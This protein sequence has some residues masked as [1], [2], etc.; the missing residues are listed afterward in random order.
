MRVG[1]DAFALDDHAGAGGVPRGLFAPG[2]VEVGQARSR[3]D[4]HHGIFEH[5]RDS[6]FVLCE[7]AR[8]ET[9]EEKH[10]HE[11]AKQGGELHRVNALRGRMRVCVERRDRLRAPDA[12]AVAALLQ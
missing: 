8:D 10:R 12:A 7:S 1:Q 9:E 6:R 5:G 4:F 2:L 11:R 3:K